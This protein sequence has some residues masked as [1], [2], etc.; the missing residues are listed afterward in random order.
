MGTGGGGVGAVVAVAVAVA[1]ATGPAD[2]GSGGVGMRLLLRL[3]RWLLPVPVWD[4]GS[5]MRGTEVPLNLRLAG[6]TSP[7]SILPSPEALLVRDRAA[8]VTGSESPAG[9]RADEE[10]DSADRCTSAPSPTCPWWLGASVGS[11]AT[12]AICIDGDG[13]DSTAGGGAPEAM[14][15]GSSAADATGGSPAGETPLPG[16]TANSALAAAATPR[17]SVRSLAPRTCGESAWGEPA[18]TAISA[19]CKNSPNPF[20]V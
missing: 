11:A 8:G 10:E 14:A 7:A 13:W 9:A 4:G 1:A 6:V 15:V 16:G 20:Q 12:A 19:E 17:P 18:D 2:G 5:G 3:A